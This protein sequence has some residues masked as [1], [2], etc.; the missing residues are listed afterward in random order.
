MGLYL[1]I[2]DGDEEID[3]VE[4]GK[5]ADFGLLRDTVRNT[6]E[7]GLAGSRFPTLMLHSDCDGSWSPLEAASLE[8]ELHT[9]SEE[10]KRL[11][12]AP[13]PTGWQIAVAKTFGLVPANLADCF[14]DVDG[15][16]LLER[17][18]ALCRRSMQLNLSILFQ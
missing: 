12:A 9:I 14:F 11:P 16:P 15:E 18:S 10:F 7:A 6:L 5:Y 4:V 2:F 17:L 13:L 3:G 8:R 1:C